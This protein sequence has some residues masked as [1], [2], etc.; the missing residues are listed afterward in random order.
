M[1]ATQTRGC[2]NGTAGWWTRCVARSAT[3]RDPAPM[4]AV[5]AEHAT[6]VDPEK[7]TVYIDCEPEPVPDPPVTPTPPPTEPAMTRPPTPE[8]TE[9]KVVML[10]TKPSGR[11][12]WTEEADDRKRGWTSTDRTGGRSPGMGGRGWVL[13]R[14]GDATCASTASSPPRDD[15]AWHADQ[16]PATEHRG[17]HG[18]HCS[19]TTP[20]T[21]TGGSTSRTSWGRSARPRRCGWRAQ[22]LGL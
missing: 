14:R 5:D 22:R 4:L 6:E 16:G 12:S 18:D 21:T 7:P 17:G 8:K 13:R 11:R 1:A 15:G 20:T 3:R 2:C 10:P 9:A 19:S